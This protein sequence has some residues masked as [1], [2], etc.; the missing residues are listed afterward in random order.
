ME[1]IERGTAE[2]VYMQL[3]AIIRAQIQSG[4]IA[5]RY[6]IPSKST[7]QQRY[8]VADGTINKAL[9]VLRDEGLV[10]TVQGLGVFVI[11]EDERPLGHP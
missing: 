5:P 7:L 2:P 9:Q 11:P 3:A 6:P 1:E 8:G 4:K 10:R